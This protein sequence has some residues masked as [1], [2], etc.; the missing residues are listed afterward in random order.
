MSLPQYGNEAFRN[1]SVLATSDLQRLKADEVV[2]ANLITT[3]VT[4]GP[5]GAVGPRGG[6]AVEGQVV[7]ASTGP[8]GPGPLMGFYN[9]TRWNYASLS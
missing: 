3:V 4:V 7:L 6:V 5:T 8:L 9:G 1:V 2:A